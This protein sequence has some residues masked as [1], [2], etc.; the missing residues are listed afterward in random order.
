MSATTIDGRWFRVLTVV[1]ANEI[2]ASKQKEI[3]MGGTVPLGHE[4]RDRALVVNEK[5]AEIVRPIFELSTGFWRRTRDSRPSSTTPL[6][7]SSSGSAIAF[8]E[9]VVSAT[10]WLHHRGTLRQGCSMKHK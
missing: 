7:G 6:S 9:Q 5:E 3:W 2:A 1:V 10:A 8:A 4:V